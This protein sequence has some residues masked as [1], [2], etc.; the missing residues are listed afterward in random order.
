MAT[1]TP[2]SKNSL[3]K[4]DNSEPSPTSSAV[5]NHHGERIEG[6]SEDSRPVRTPEWKKPEG[7]GKRRRMAVR[8][9][10]FFLYTSPPHNDL[11]KQRS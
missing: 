11:D 3:I 7:L 6:A 5:S 10:A 2:K 8:L 4:H 9:D 1:T